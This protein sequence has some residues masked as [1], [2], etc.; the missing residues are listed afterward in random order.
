MN[1]PGEIKTLSE[2]VKPQIGVI[3]NVSEAHIQNFTNL[4]GIAKAKAEIIKSITKNGTMILNKDD[5][6][7]NFLKN[8]QK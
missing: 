5:K 3:T 6:F 8:C 2:M 4:N 1:K 7:F